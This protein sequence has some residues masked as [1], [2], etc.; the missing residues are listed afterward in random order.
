MKTGLD[1][2]N[3]VVTGAG[4]GIGLATAKAF[5]AEGA[6]VVGVDMNPGEIEPL[7]GSRLVFLKKDLT[8]AR[9]G[10]EV[11]SAAVEAFGPPAVL[12]NCAGIAPVRESALDGADADWM[13]SIDVNFLSVVR[14]CR[15]LIPAM[16]D[17]GGGSV[18]SVASDAARMPDPF[19]AEYNVTKASIVMFMKTL[20]IEF[21][22]KNV[23][24][25][26]V[27]PGPTRTPMWD[28]P[29][30]FADSLAEQLGLSTEE[31]IRHFA[32]TMRRLPLARLASVDEVAA[33]NVFLSSPLASFVTG[34]EYTVNGG[35]IPTI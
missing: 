19:F 16:V 25:N 3:V 21:G 1:G 11:L 20:S 23:R 13:H 29:G 24:V 7:T 4:S 17:A 9:V 6:N 30:G 15:A 26:T 22:P 34:A 31:A 27:S 32:T 14:M 33:V 12:V 35:S 28:R 2:K 10:D 5:L 18:V 8:E